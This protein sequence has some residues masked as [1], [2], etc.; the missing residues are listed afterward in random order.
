MSERVAHAL[1]TASQEADIL[2]DRR[3][4]ADG[5]EAEIECEVGEPVAA[6]LGERQHQRRHL[7][8]MPARIERR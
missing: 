5:I 2:P 8:A 1:A 7:A 6:P 3:H 4:G